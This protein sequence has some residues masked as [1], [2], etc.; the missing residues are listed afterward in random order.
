MTDEITTTTNE[1]EQDGTSSHLLKVFASPERYV[2]GPNAMKYL[3]NEMKKLNMK[4]PVLVVSSETPRTLLEEIWR[5]S[6]KEN[7]YDEIYYHSFGGICSDHE[8]KRIVAAAEAIDAKTLI[9]IGGGQVIDSV[10]TASIKIPTPCE[11]VSCPTIASTD[12]PCSTLCVLYHENEQTGNKE[13]HEYRFT[14]R[15]PT[16]VLVDTTVIANAPRRLLVGGLGGTYI[17]IYKYI[18]IFVRVCVCVFNIM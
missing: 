5:S 12:A 8:S 14:K 1:E 17:Y 2:Q 11:V 7:G 13:F 6:L 16:L 10:R 4:G 18:Y 3:G 15:H 9:G